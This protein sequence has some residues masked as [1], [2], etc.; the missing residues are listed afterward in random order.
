MTTI[1]YRFSNPCR[2]KVIA[3]DLDHTLIK[4]LNGHKFSKSKDDCELMYPEITLKLNELRS[5][6]FKLVVFTNQRNKKSPDD[7]YYKVSKLLGDDIDIFISTGNDG[8][9]K[10]MM[11]MFDV[12]VKLNDET[13]ISKNE[14]VYVGDA[15]GRPNDFSDSDFRFALN[16]RAQFH[17][18]EEFF[19]NH[20]PRL[21]YSTPSPCP[22]AN[23]KSIPWSET[24]GPK[25]MIIHVGM[26]GSGKSTLTKHIVQSYDNVV[27]ISNDIT[28]TQAKRLRMCRESVMNGNII[29]V[30]N[31]NPSN[32]ARSP[33][34]YIASTRN[35][36]IWIVLHL[37]PQECCQYLNKLRSYTQKCPCVPEIAYR[38]FHKNL[39]IREDNAAQYL[40]MGLGH[41]I[42]PYI[43][44]IDSSPWYF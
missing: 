31:T 44:Q 12:F 14:F 24:I 7:I 8:Y 28:K 4:P 26:P 21:E 22:L 20:L 11:G 1:F 3:F 10:P 38:M 16:I 19:L 32:S 36:K 25:T 30:D 17:T 39:D 23:V 41:R 34:V 42:I 40:P 15:A 29:V 37:L 27:V 6:G 9:R 35:Y 13:G 33:Y 5:L 2:N 18:P 43:P